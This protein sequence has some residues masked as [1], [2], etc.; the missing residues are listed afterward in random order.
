MV[1]A[2]GQDCQKVSA[3]RA[4]HALAYDPKNPPAPPLPAN[5][6]PA[7]SDFFTLKSAT[8]LQAVIDTT[9]NNRAKLMFEAANAG[10]ATAAKTLLEQASSSS[11]VTVTVR[12]G[13]HQHDDRPAGVVGKALHFTI[14]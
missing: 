13:L 5:S 7:G 8:E 6:F 2:L 4:E 10:A 1:L 3:F 12:W 14:R 11:A 9:W